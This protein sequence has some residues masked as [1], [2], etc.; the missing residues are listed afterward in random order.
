MTPPTL[1]EI[2]FEP[3]PP[4]DD[5][6]SPILDPEWCSLR[7]S[8][9]ESWASLTAR[10]GYLRL[11][12]RESLCSRNKVSLIARRIQSFHFQAE[13]C[14]EFEPEN[15][16]QM[17]GLVCL[18]DDINHYYL[19]IYYSDSLKSR[20]LGLMSA[21]NGVRSEHLDSRVAIPGQGRVYLKVIVHE[22]EMAFKYSLNGT[23]WLAIGPV[24]DASKLSDEYCASG[25]FTGAFVGITAQDFY[26]RRSHADFDYFEYSE[27]TANHR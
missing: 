17:A 2:G 19:R 27:C 10:S 5:F 20:C 21:D 3:Q 7:H 18:Y 9:D 1:P 26:L 11:H 6:D 15:F 24:F 22:K 13:T 8:V 4:R 23:N 25:Q 12:G 14:I 16:Q